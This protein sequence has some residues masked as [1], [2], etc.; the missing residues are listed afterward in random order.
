MPGQQAGRLGSR[1]AERLTDRGRRGDVAVVQ[2]PADRHAQA[3]RGQPVGLMGAALL[4]RELGF[5]R[6]RRLIRGLAH[7]SMVATATAGVILAPWDGARARP[8]ALRPE[9][10]VYSCAQTSQVPRRSLALIAACDR[11]RR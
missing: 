2:L 10:T 1:H 8:R 11:R 4:G 9:C 7:A 3:D 6:W 5:S